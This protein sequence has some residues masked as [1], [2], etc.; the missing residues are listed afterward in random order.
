MQKST[1][2]AMREFDKY[3]GGYSPSSETWNALAY[4]DENLG[5]AEE[6]YY[7]YLGIYRGILVGRNGK[8]W[9]RKAKRKLWA[10]IT[11]LKQQLAEE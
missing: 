2:R 6:V 8:K 10:E 3:I 11:A 7:Y 9:G 4:A 1:K 5:I